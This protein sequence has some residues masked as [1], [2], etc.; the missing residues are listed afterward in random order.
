[1]IWLE[2]WW[3]LKSLQVFRVFS[4]K[5]LVGMAVAD[6]RRRTGDCHLD[7]VLQEKFLPKPKIAVA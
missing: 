3:V 7:G 2:Q 6:D 1:V 5:R 4:L